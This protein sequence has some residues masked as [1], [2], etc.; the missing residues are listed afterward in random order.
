MDDL[1]MNTMQMMDLSRNLATDHL[2][3]QTANQATKSS[4]E[5]ELMQSAKETSEAANEN[6]ANNDQTVKSADSIENK[7]SINAAAKDLEAVFL[8]QMLSPIF[9]NM[10]T[11][12]L[13]GGGH[14]EQVYR[15]MIVQ[16]YGKSMAEN[17]G[18]GLQKYIA[19]Q[20]AQYQ[21]GAK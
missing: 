10:G 7:D 5:K 21:E 4:F 19:N 11:D 8:S 18:I 13:F 2:L 1:S 9:E 20:I 15:G 17:G 14:A 12:P 3:K 16:E 6:D